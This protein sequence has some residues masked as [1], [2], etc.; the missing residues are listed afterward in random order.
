MSDATTATE[1]AAPGRPI[2]RFRPDGW[3]NLVV[4]LPGNQIVIG[5][6]G[7]GAQDMVK[8]MY[9]DLRLWQE[10]GEWW[11]RHYRTFDADGYVVEDRAWVTK[12]VVGFHFKPGPTGPTIQDRQ[13]AVLEKIA[14]HEC[15]GG[16]DDWKKGT[17]NDEDE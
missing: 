5:L 14:N 3:Y 13:I 7:V 15:D 10:K 6:N 2:M 8:V 1:P 16:A 9:S 4:M 11:T 17:P 12:E